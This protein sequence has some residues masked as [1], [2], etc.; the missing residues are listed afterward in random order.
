V[1]AGKVPSLK[2]RKE[3]TASDN[4]EKNSACWDGEGAS[5]TAA[6]Q[7]PEGRRKVHKK[8]TI[9]VPVGSA[10]QA[11]GERKKGRGR[12]IPGATRPKKMRT[13]SKSLPPCY[14]PAPVNKALGTKSVCRGDKN[15]IPGP[16]AGKR[17][18]KETSG[19]A[20]GNPHPPTKSRKKTKGA[21]M[22]PLRQALPIGK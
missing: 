4:H 1:L 6:C 17:P 19:G 14:N 7:K 18:T 22:V 10:R 16:K 8:K 20:V 5:P 2:K 9:E 15:N 21:S 12:E 13:A 11:I 3:E